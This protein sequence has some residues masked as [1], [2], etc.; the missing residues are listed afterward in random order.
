MK[1]RVNR[2]ELAEALGVVGS[3]AATRTP[4]DILKCV[5]LRAA[6]DHLELEGTDLEISIRF[7]V[8]QVEVNKKGV[9]LVS[10]E[11]L[12]AIVRESNDELLDIETDANHCHVRGAGSHFQIYIRDAKEFPAGA[13]MS[14][15]PDWEIKANVLRH[16]AER[17]IFAAARENTRYAIN[18]VLWERK[19]KQ[20]VMVATDGRRL[21]KAVGKISGGKDG[22]PSEV[23]VPSKAMVLFQRLFTEQDEKI[24][25]K[26]TESQI[27]LRSNRATVS[28]ALVEGHFPNYHDV[29]PKET[30]KTAQLK[31]G[32]TLSGIR[33]AA[34]LTNEE[35]RGVRF[36]F[37]DA[38]LTLSSRAPQEGEASVKLAVAYKGEALEI[39]FNPN[40]LTD[41][42][43]VIHDDEVNFELKDANRPGVIK[44]GDDYL[45][46]V[47][48]VNLS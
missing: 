22:G 48:P 40:F 8:S 21:A 7:I 4:K 41:V 44:C 16:L 33:R 2:Q 30:N 17:T 28:V 11:K 45:Y 1:V 32:E 34:L 19:D 14:G 36:A 42:L 25:V 15:D 3:V 23:I 37:A 47:M 13:S 27:V 31:V 46:V 38:E 10:A 35:S 12:S 24:G 5:L 29:I 43:K 18:G 20:L 39:G 26:L 6:A 9:V